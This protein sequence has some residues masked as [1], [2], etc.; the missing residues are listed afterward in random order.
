MISLLGSPLL[1]SSARGHEQRAEAGRERCAASLSRELAPEAKEREGEE[2][3][4][5]AA[6]GP[7]REVSGETD[8]EGAA[9]ARS[10]VLEAG[11]GDADA[12]FG[13]G[14]RKREVL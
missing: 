2:G 6:G 1:K 14:E 9:V 11:V 3:G 4:L 12:L 13:A 8:G 5:Q 10:V 7:R